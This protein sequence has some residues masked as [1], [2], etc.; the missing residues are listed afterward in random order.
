MVTLEGCFKIF[1]EPEAGMKRPFCA[2][3]PVLILKTIQLY[4]SSWCVVGLPVFDYACFPG[5]VSNLM[6]V[7]FSP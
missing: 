1:R 3:V 6:P 5:M 7:S 4:L 2:K